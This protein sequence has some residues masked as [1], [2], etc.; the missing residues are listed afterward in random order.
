LIPS[1]GG[2]AAPFD[3]AL[4]AAPVALPGAAAV[5]PAATGSGAPAADA[6][7]SAVASERGGAW[8]VRAR[9]RWTLAR[10]SR[11]RRSES[12][13]AVRWAAGRSESSAERERELASESGGSEDRKGGDR[14]GAGAAGEVPSA[15]EGRS[16]PW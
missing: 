10:S 14:D 12:V 16:A 3:G 7:S 15:S 9:S 5:L 13:W 11:V 8:W 1:G 6:G 4:P 2:W